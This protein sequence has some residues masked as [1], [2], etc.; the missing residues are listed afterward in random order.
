MKNILP[1]KACSFGITREAYK[2]VYFKHNPSVDMTIPGPGTYT[3]G[4]LM[5]KEGPLFT[6]K[7]KPKNLSI[8][9]EKSTKKVLLIREKKV[10][11]LVLMNQFLA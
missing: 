1:K 8:F 3:P 2:K 11:V 7:S 6:L 9:T 5:G 10:Q 4:G